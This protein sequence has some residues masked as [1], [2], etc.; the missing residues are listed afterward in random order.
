MTS[1]SGEIFTKVCVLA[2]CGVRDVTKMLAVAVGVKCSASGCENPA[3]GFGKARTC[4]RK[5]ISKNRAWSSMTV[6]V[7]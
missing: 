1:A 4:E 3:E 2:G 5:F 6:V 7:N